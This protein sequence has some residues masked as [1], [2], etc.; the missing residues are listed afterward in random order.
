MVNSRPFRT[1]L[2]SCKEAIACSVCGYLDES[3]KTLHAGPWLS[4]IS[5]VVQLPVLHLK[6]LQSNLYARPDERKIM[7]AD[8]D[9]P[10]SHLSDAHFQATA[11]LYNSAWGPMH[12]LWSRVGLPD[13]P[14]PDIC[15]APL[16]A[17]PG[18]WGMQ[19]TSFLT[20]HI[21]RHFRPFYQDADGTMLWVPSSKC[22]SDNEPKNP[23]FSGQSQQIR[24]RELLFY[25]EQPR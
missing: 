24:A 11:A 4:N 12:C 10:T 17:R 8:H 14:S 20:A 16:C 15:A 18:H 1:F 9:I 19:G 3:L 13:S 21:R 7:G 5:G 2:P 23:F 25:M 22:S 6:P